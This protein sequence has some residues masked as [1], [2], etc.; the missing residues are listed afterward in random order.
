MDLQQQVSPDE[1]DYQDGGDMGPGEGEGDYDDGE[2]RQ[3]YN[4]TVSSALAEQ[5]NSRKRTQEDVKL[6]ANRIQL[7]KLEE[8]KVSQ[9]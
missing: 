8:K 7:L 3:A 2:N 4:K 5:R 9:T 6:L 1:A